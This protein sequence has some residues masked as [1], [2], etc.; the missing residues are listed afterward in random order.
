M[1]YDQDFVAEAI[2]YAKIRGIRVI[3]E[4]GTPG[5]TLSWGL[6]YPHLLSP[7]YDVPNLNSGPLNPTKNSTYT[8]VEDLFAELK[9]IFKDK[10]TH[11]GGDEVEFKCW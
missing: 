9:S 2:E 11:L 10:F 8:F 3:P 6:E 7:C 1:V 5:H 4:F